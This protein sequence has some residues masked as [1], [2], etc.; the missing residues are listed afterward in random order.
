MLT[1]CEGADVDVVILVA[2]VPR[3]E[4]EDRRPD[5][6]VGENPRFQVMELWMVCVPAHVQAPWLF[7]VVL[8]LANEALGIDVGS[9][10][11]VECFD[12]GRVNVDACFAHDA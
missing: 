7:A 4:V 11:E 10:L 8:D 5:S 6:E 9:G 3:R 1:A 12:F 2:Y